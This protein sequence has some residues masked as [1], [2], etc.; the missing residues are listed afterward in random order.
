MVRTTRRI[1]VGALALAS[2]FVLVPAAQAW[3]PPTGTIHEQL[4]YEATGQITYS[5]AP[6]HVF[7]SEI[8]ALEGDDVDC[9]SNASAEF[10]DDGWGMGN[11]MQWSALAYGNQCE[12]LG[13]T[14]GTIEHSHEWTSEGDGG[15]QTVQ[16][17]NGPYITFSFVDDL[18]GD[19]CEADDLFFYAA[20]DEE[21]PCTADY[22]G[23]TGAMTFDGAEDY[24]L[25]IED[26]NDARAPEGSRVSIDGTITWYDPW[27]TWAVPDYD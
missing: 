17:T 26:S 27:E 10:H 2:V 25:I 6:T 21:A 18:Q 1:L 24:C 4:G 20:V 9:D 15:N 8:A 23:T 13:C 11:Y 7:M 3:T 14:V 5:I 19:P 12:S 22:D 16:F